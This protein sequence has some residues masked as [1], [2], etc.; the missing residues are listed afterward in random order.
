MAY[1]F[2][3][4][5]EKTNWKYIL[6]IVILALIVAG[7]TLYLAKQEVKIP[8]MKLPEKVVEEEIICGVSDPLYCKNN[9]DCICE[10]AGCFMGNRHYYDKCI[11]KE[12]ICLDYCGLPGL[13]LISQCI[14][15][16]CTFEPKSL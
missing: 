13:T 1:I 15:N 16:R 7:E 6:I 9:Q 8:E 2:I 11:D 4:R 5:K 12:K 14:R 10:A 3:T